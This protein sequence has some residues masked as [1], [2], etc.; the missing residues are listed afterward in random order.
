MLKIGKI[1]ESLCLKE[2]DVSLMWQEMLV[3]IVGNGRRLGFSNH[4]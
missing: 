2:L 1:L 3:L 4:R